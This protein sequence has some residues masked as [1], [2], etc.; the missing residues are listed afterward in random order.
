MRGKKILD[1]QLTKQE[2]DDAHA[3]TLILASIVPIQKTHHHKITTEVS[4]KS[5]PR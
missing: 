3:Q 2:S 4:Q 1:F 5:E